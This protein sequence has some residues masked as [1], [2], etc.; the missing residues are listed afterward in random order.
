M[1]KVSVL[2]DRRV[3]CN[4]LCPNHLH[5]RKQISASNSLVCSRDLRGENVS[6]ETTD[7]EQVGLS[8]KNRVFLQLMDK[9]FK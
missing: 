2:S 4:E 8:V 7:D 9:T 3:T 5:I 6:T 1:K